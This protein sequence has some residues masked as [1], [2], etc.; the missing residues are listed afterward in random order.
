[1]KQSQVASEPVSSVQWVRRE[2]VRANDYNPNRVSPRELGLLK[3]SIIQDGWT[4]TDR[5]GCGR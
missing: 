1:M 4:P 2:L 3:L 5:D